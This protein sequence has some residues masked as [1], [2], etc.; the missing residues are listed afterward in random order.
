MDV[1]GY[2]PNKTAVKLRAVREAQ[3]LLAWGKDG[4]RHQPVYSSPDGLLETFYLYPTFDCPLRCPFCYA[5]GGVRS[6][7]ELPAD[8]LV[9]IT[10]EAMEAGYRKVTFVGGEPLAYREFDKLLEGLQA[11]RRKEHAGHATGSEA[12]APSMVGNGCQLILRSSLGFEV[13]PSLLATIAETFDEVTVSIDGDE[14]THDA[15][16]GAGVYRSTVRNV[17]ALL[18]MG[19]CR[20]GVNSV[21][22]RDEFDG[23]PGTSVRAFCDEHRIDKLTI[24]NPVPMGRAKKT[25][26]NADD[27]YEWHKGTTLMAKTT[28]CYSCGLGKSLYMQPDGTV[29]PCYAWYETHHKLGDLSREHVR[30]ILAR[31]EILA[32]L[33]SGVD[34]NEKCSQCDVRY[35]CGGQ[36]KVWARDKR[37]V[38]SGDFDC[39]AKKAEILEAVSHLDEWEARLSE[40]LR[41]ELPDAATDTATAVSP[42]CRENPRRQGRD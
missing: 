23:I 39:T 42:S 40:Q 27:Y 35:L 16:R 4:T 32:Y 7:Q 9:R 3:K 29:Y 17:E 18:G 21:M 26:A 6:C 34:T 5:D 36:C 37:N 15:Q 12:S 24:Q 19:T 33:N 11:L 20:V 25:G 22:E 41:E 14:A 38:D 30:D 10:W 13:D 1:F 28:P 8:D 2:K 31:P